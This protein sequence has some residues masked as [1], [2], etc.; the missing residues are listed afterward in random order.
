V[1]LQSTIVA[2]NAV[3]S[4]NSKPDIVSSIFPVIAINSLIENAA[5]TEFSSSSVNNVFGSD[6][7]LLPLADNGGPTK[8]H[9]LLPGSPA[10]NTGLNFTGQATDQRGG[11]FVR[12]F[13]PAADIGAFEVQP[14]PAQ[15]P[16]PP[17]PPPPSPEQ[18][19]VIA[20]PSGTAIQ[21]AV[22]IIQLLQRDGARVAAVA[23]GELNNDLTTDI[24][25]AFRQ[26][27]GKLLVVTVNG[28][29]GQIHSVF[30]PFPAKLK[31]G[32]KV[33]LLTLDFS[34]DPGLEIGLL[35]R[36]GGAGVPGATVFTGTGTRVF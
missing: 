31:N 8:T 18:P 33:Q 14:P 19:R 21:E 35:V 1:T 7:L 26:R 27:S 23:F 25:L 12:V 32:A 28:A 15:P 6:P 3:G 29:S 17:P 13:G 4:S 36:K 10:I 30:V 11:P 20:P 2:K 5:G 9:A 16:P 24:V 22:R 34:P